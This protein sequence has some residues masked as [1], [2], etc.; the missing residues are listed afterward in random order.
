[1]CPTKSQVNNVAK[2]AAKLHEKLCQKELQTITNPSWSCRT[3]KQKK[4]TKQ[5]NQNIRIFLL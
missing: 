1:M 5:K 3:L 2:T 4:K